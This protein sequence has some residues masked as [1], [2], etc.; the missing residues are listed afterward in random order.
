[1]KKQT[2]KAG[3]APR[4]L[5]VGAGQTQVGKSASKNRGPYRKSAGNGEKLL[6]EN[7]KHFSLFGSAVASG[8]V[9]LNDGKCPS[10]TKKPEKYPEQA[11]SGKIK[12]QLFPFNEVTQMGLEKDGYHPYLELTLNA[13]KK[14][15]SVLKH[16]NQK[17][18]SSS[19]ATKDPFLLPYNL[20]Q[21]LAS[22]RWTLNDISVSAGDVY[23][24]IGRPSE[25][26]LRYG[27]LS[28]CQNES[29][30]VPSMSTSF[31]TFLQPEGMQK[32]CR[33]NDEST[34]AKEK[35]TEETSK[36]FRPTFVG[37]ATDC[38]DGKVHV[39][40]GQSSL[41][42]DSLTN[43]SIG[44]LLSEASL[45]GQFGTYDPKSDGSNAGLHPSQLISDSLDAFITS[46]V[47]HSQAPR[48]PHGTSSSILD[49]EDTCH[50]FA[51]QKFSS[52]GKEAV[53]AGGSASSHAPNQDAVSRLLKDPN[54]NEVNNQSGLP[55]SH[56][57]QE[58]ET[59]LPFYS[60][61]YND[62]SSL[63]LSGIKWT[64][65]SGPFDLGL[66]SSRKIINGDS[67]SFNRTIS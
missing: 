41:W 58:S 2:A 13:R 22:C 12:L 3:E 19:I 40:V 56:G 30:E 48:L 57:C 62:E 45:Q 14:I 4:K 42:D 55:Q 28:N 10:E 36:E 38:N 46:H 54:I 66:S 50:A 47:N 9:H 23:A 51:F 15:S 61:L 60:R 64:D 63:G 21:D 37:G 6:V 44:G 11:L 17:W 18:G 7:N 43:I 32:V 16:L 65:S 24:A 35:Q 67:L 26:R 5:K 53:A 27:W 29:S 1:M 31:E 25:F 33:Y 34:R 8:P 59:P 52:L 20:C 39:G 49:A